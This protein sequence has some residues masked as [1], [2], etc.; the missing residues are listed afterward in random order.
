MTPPDKIYVSKNTIDIIPEN[1][2]H[3]FLFDIEKSEGD[4]E[5]IRNDGWLPIETGP[6]DGTEVDLWIVPKNPKS[7]HYSE[8]RVMD[9]HWHYDRWTYGD[10]HFDIGPIHIATHWRPVPEPPEI[11]G[12]EITLQV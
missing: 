12:S 2:V 11:K 9:C 3:R 7:K 4:I 5:Y 10:G 8:G 1:R 6:K